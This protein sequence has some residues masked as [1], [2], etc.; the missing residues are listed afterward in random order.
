MEDGGGQVEAQPII[1]NA[2][3]EELAPIALGLAENGTPLEGLSTLGAVNGEA[4]L[5]DAVPVREEKPEEQTDLLRQQIVFTELNGSLSVK[6]ATFERLATWAASVNNGTHSRS[7]HSFTSCR[8]LLPVLPP[9]HFCLWVVVFGDV[10]VCH[11]SLPRC[12]HT[13]L[14]PTRC[15]DPKL[16]KAFLMCYRNFGSPTDLFNVLLKLCVPP[17]CLT[18][19]MAE[20]GCARH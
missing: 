19:H 11:V 7:A 16:S 8:G 2:S 9:F 15:A 20:D 17:L 3:D 10:V 4:G 18:T 13:D 5:V 1:Q 6:G 12:T 14:K